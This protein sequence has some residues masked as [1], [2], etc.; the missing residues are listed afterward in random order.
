MVLVLVSLRHILALN[1]TMILLLY[2]GPLISFLPGPEMP[3]ESISI[4]ILSRD[5]QFFG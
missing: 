5:G 4:F 1:S 2:V 3:M